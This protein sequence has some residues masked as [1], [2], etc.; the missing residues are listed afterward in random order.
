MFV[1]DTQTGHVGL[2][3]FENVLFRLRVVQYVRL[4]EF[5]SGLSSVDNDFQAQIKSSKTN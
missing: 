4:G 2:V 3:N 1:G 5:N